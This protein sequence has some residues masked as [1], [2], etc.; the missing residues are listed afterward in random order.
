M[1]PTNSQ[2]PMS[3]VKVV[4]ANPKHRGK[5]VDSYKETDEQRHTFENNKSAVVAA[6]N[7]YWIPDTIHINSNPTKH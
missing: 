7:K 5:K 4:P 3:H 1:E 6:D 2:F